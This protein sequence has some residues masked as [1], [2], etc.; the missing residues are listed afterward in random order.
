MTSTMAEATIMYAWSP[1]EYHWF[2]FSTARANCLASSVY[3]GASSSAGSNGWDTWKMGM[4]SRLTR[5]ATREG[6]GAVESGGS[7]NP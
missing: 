3:V 4:D 7:S 5:V 2:R 1:G 6:I